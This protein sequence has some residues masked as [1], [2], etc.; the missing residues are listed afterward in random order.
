MHSNM[1]RPVTPLGIIVEK[2]DKILA[3]AKEEGVFVR[4]RRFS[5]RSL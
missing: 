5:S 2:L 1:P 4:I 3:T